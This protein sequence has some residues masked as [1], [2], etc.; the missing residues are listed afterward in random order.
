MMDD[1][2]AFGPVAVLIPSLRKFAEDLDRQCGLKMNAAK[3][4]FFGFALAGP[5]IA[6]LEA[7]GY[8]RGGF[9]GLA[10]AAVGTVVGNGI[11]VS[12][13]PVGEDS[14]IAA[15]LQKK[16]DESLSNLKIVIDKLHHR[17]RQGAFC[18]L[19]Y[20]YAQQQTHWLGMCTPT[21]TEASAGVYWQGLKAAL[22]QVLHKDIF[23]C[24]LVERL[25]QKRAKL[26]GAGI[27]N[28]V[29]VRYAAFLGQ[30]LLVVKEMIDAVNHGVLT[31]GYA[32]DTMGDLFGA[33]AM[34]DGGCD[35][36][37]WLAAP[38]A[39]ASPF[40]AGI[41]EAYDALRQHLPDA[42]RDVEE[43]LGKP[44][45]VIAEDGKDHLQRV[46]TRQVERHQM[47]QL[48]LDFLALPRTEERRRAF[49]NKG[50]LASAW[51]TAWTD[52]DLRVTNPLFAEIV[53]TY[54]GLT[55][56]SADLLQ[57]VVMING[58][59]VD[60]YANNLAALRN[61]TGD[62]FRTR[63]DAVKLTVVDA[64]RTCSVGAAAEVLNLFSAQ[65]GAAQRAAFVRDNSYRKRQSY[66]PDILL[67]F[68]PPDTPQDPMLEVKSITPC[69]V[70]YPT[71][72]QHADTPF[73]GVNRRAAQV[74]NECYKKAHKVDVQYAGSPNTNLPADRGPV[75]QAMRAMEGPIPAVFGAYGETNKEFIHIL[76][77]LAATGARTQWRQMLFKTEEIA[78][79]VF[80]W[81]VRR[82]VGM[83]ILRA[84]AILKRSRMLLMLGLPTDT[85]QSREAASRFRVWGRNG[86]GD[87]A[88]GYRQAQAR[89]N[90]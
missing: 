13:A 26:G 50:E 54:F 24:P 37:S 22:Q 60:R 29:E 20:C 71:T 18:L 34:D 86:R 32:Q 48:K 12:G 83:A 64:A 40:T 78:L 81:R 31:V 49:L 33:G 62:G 7:A 38:G 56:P 79:G 16:C 3:S 80:T 39:Y 41:K 61:Y 30:Q 42:V 68:P 4:Q 76:A 77:K 5:E 1:C 43:P 63:H 65:L 89:H 82:Q 69:S 35:L 59:V 15:V 17:S 10:D 21:Q 58:R 27:R 28:P 19:F 72:G 70:W 66:V 8:K 84:N 51:V 47:A 75:E 11:E 45:A 2:Y 67:N 44:L 73:W 87:I 53:A 14:Y 90:A 6:A 85:A 55:S 52:P 36:T 57:G 74:P 46:Y 25:V 23:Q 88:A 9:S